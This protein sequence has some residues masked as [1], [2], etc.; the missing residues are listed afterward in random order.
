MCVF[1][2]TLLKFTEILK[3]NIKINEVINRSSL[4][5]ENV[6]NIIILIPKYK[7]LCLTILN[8]YLIKFFFF[9]E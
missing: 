9:N 7:Y 3:I 4:L 6:K 2:S 8:I 5:K 1:L